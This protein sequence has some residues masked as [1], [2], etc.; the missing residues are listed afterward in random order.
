[1]KRT[2]DWRSAAGSTNTSS[3]SGAFLAQVGL[4]CNLHWPLLQPKRFSESML[5]LSCASRWAKGQRALHSS[6]CV[7]YLRNVGQVSRAICSLLGAT[8]QRGQL[9]NAEASKYQ[10][11]SSNRSV[12]QQTKSYSHHPIDRAS[13]SG[14]L[15]AFGWRC[16]AMTID[17]NGTSCSWC[18]LS[19]P[20]AIEPHQWRGFTAAGVDSKLPR[21]ALESDMSQARPTNTFHEAIGRQV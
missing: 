4:S 16:H 6:G 2:S 13:A 15:S 8:P 11:D 7:P 10:L 21:Q 5:I 14:Q 19:A 3:I 18:R 12:Y 1:M 9:L 17:R 20:S